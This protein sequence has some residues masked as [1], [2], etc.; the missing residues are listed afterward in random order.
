MCVG[1]I[2]KQRIEAIH[3]LRERSKELLNGRIE[4]KVRELSFGSLPRGALN[5]RLAKDHTF[6]VEKMTTLLDHHR[7]PDVVGRLDVVAKGRLDVFDRLGNGGCF[8]RQ[9]FPSK[10][11]VFIQSMLVS[12]SVNEGIAPIGTR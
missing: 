7:M 3:A 11:V 8:D 4:L 12:N 9:G 6:L 1:R 2:E 10:E 5:E